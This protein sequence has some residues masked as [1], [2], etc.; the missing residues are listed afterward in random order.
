[1]H[2]H[3]PATLPESVSPVTL[4]PLVRARALRQP[5]GEAVVGGGG[6]RT[7]AE[8][9][10]RAAGVGHA[11][12]R[13]GVGRGDRVGILAT[14]STEWIEVLLGTLWI[15]AVVVPLNYRLAP[16]ECRRVLEDAGLTALVVAPDLSPAVRFD[17]PTLRLDASHE[18]ALAGAARDEPPV[19][20][21]PEDLAVIVYTSGT[22]ALPKGVMWSHGGLLAS[23]AVNPFP[24]T[25]AAGAR[26]LVC[27]PLC[28]G[29][30][31]LMACNALA[32]GATLVVAHFTPEAVL[33]M[34]AEDGIQFTG[35]VPTML[36][37]LLDAAPA[38]WHPGALR[39]IYY[40][41]G[42]LRPELYA[43]A[44]SVFGCELQ[45]AYGM[46]ETCIMGTRLDPAD[47]T[48]ERLG[49]A[50]RPMPGVAITLVDETG[51]PV[52]AGTPGEILIRSPGNMLGYWRR[53]AETQA[54][55]A[56]GWYHSRDVGRLDEAGCLQ[57]L[58]RLDDMVKSGGFNVSPT[59]VEGVLLAHPGVEEAAVIG[60]PD[61]RWGQRVTAIVRPRAGAILHEQDLLAHCRGR[62]AGFKLPRA[63]FFTE[64]PL[65]RNALGK[66]TR[67]ELRTRYGTP[68]GT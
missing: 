14:N 16:A 60:L 36:A 43:R 53:P 40:G 34:L 13:L 15:G 28:A 65:P 9:A 46:T 64:A 41:A 26:I 51:V 12:R 25:L 31:L 18:R 67:R 47:H 20:V 10:T 48:P 29:G 17:G 66:V 42:T 27:A 32:I 56:D 54:A 44:R 4:A 23:A 1:V 62:L 58:D 21:A 35:L 59:E 22:T 2:R 7:W 57:L 52:P 63:I 33:R 24:S 5:A 68:E 30:A 38:T 3:R 55:L 19:E 6:R 49:S 37:L 11:L 45:Q 39:R 8:L 50:G 61:G